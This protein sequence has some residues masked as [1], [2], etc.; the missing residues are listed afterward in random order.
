[1]P[2]NITHK[3]SAS[4]LPPPP[5]PRAVNVTTTLTV[6][7]L[8]IFIDIKLQIFAYIKLRH[9]LSF[10]KS[11]SKVMFDR[12]ARQGN[13]NASL[14]ECLDVVN[15]THELYLS[16]L[17][18]NIKVNIHARGC[19][20][21]SISPWTASLNHVQPCPSYSPCACHDRWPLPN[22]HP[23]VH[24]FGSTSSGRNSTRHASLNNGG[25]TPENS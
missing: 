11:N 24:K 16:H 7:F 22:A 3:E 10:P 21:V 15:S 5:R 14:M 2:K 8:T 13:R 4:S 19:L 9:N 23:L 20:L 6:M 25:G 17:A 12:F 18:S 1:M